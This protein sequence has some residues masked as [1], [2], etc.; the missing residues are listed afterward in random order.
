MNE[1]QKVHGL[2]I[3]W[4]EDFKAKFGEY[5]EAKS[6]IEEVESTLKLYKDVVEK[7]KIPLDIQRAR[8]ARRSD[9]SVL[10]YGLE[11]HLS[12]FENSV[13]METI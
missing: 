2:L 1:Q 12:K 13:T 3:Q 8:D 11:H 6:T 5:S 7:V 9:G 4:L 10:E